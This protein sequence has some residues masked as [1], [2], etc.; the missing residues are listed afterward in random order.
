MATMKLSLIAA[1]SKNRVIGIDNR[2]P[3]HLSADLK[4]F[5]AVT[6][7]KPILMGRKTYQSIGRPLPGRENIVLTSDKAYRAEGCSVAHSLDQALEAVAHHP[8]AMIIGGS[9]LYQA[10][11]PLAERLYLT[12]IDQDFQGDTFFP[13]FDESQWREVECR[14]VDNDPAVSFAYAFTIWDRKV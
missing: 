2:M 6:W 11:L 9:A 13:E 14:L 4:R 8:E 5:R 10:A 7:G 3:W 12:R 1:M